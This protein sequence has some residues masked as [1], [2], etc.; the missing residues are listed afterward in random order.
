MPL[1]KQPAFRKENLKGVIPKTT[2]APD[3]ER[4][5]LTGSE[6]FKAK[7][8]TLPHEILLADRE[9]LNLV[10]SSIEKIKENVDELL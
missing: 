4:L 3:Y 9:A 1:Y 2:R 8:I 10:V 6:E 7:E 5:Y